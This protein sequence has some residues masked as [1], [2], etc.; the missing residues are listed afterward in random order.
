MRESLPPYR[1][2]QGFEARG[3]L[4]SR[5]PALECQPSVYDVRRRQSEMDV[6]RCLTH[7]LTSCTQKR[8][9]IVIGLSLDILHSANITYR[10]ANAF[11]RLFWYPVASPPGLANCLLNVEPP[12]DFRSFGP[13][14]AHLGQSIAI[15]HTET[16]HLHRGRRKHPACVRGKYTGKFGVRGWVSRWRLFFREIKSLIVEIIDTHTHLD[17]D[18]FSGNLDEV[19]ATSR[20]HGVGKWINVGYSPARWKTTL[21]LVE[22]VEG[23]NHM[24]GIHPGNADEWNEETAS[25]LGELVRHTDPVA[26]GE[27]GIDLHWRSDNLEIQT[28]SFESQMALAVEANLP[29]VIHMRSADQALLDVLSR[30]SRLPELHFHSF[31]GSEAL[32]QWIVNHGCTIGVG[33]LMTR[34]GS[35][36]LRSW[37]ANVP[38]DRVVLETDSPYLKPQGIRGVRNQPAFLPR[39]AAELANLWGVSLS[40]VGRITTDNACR[41]FNLKQKDHVTCES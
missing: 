38:T 4:I 28:K 1:F 26:I 33:G 7:T 13:D 37:I 40:E 32:R 29:A 14:G 34:K 12:V 10:D 35:N 20:A 5:L 9:H 17:D 18:A 36:S 3:K 30:V 6:P 19:I 23:M 21:G 27:I 22:R 39:V 16:L 41:I 25:L 8:D 31:D 2:D 24:L 15:D 11:Y